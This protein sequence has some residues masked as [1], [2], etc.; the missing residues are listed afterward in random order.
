M[1]SHPPRE[2]ARRIALYLYM[3]LASAW[4]LG[5][6]VVV[7]LAAGSTDLLWLNMLKGVAFAVAT[8]LALYLIISRELEQRELLDRNHR[9]LTE[10]V[11]DL[12]FRLRVRPDLGF[13][14]VSPASVD[15][16]GYAPHEYYENP[17]AVLT[18][19]H[20]DDRERLSA[21]LSDPDSELEETELRWRH[22]DGRMVWTDI[23]V[24]KERDDAGR[25]VYISGVLRD[26]TK[27]RESERVRALLAETLEAAGEAVIITGRDGTI[28]YVNRAFTEIT[29]YDRE[30]A[31]GEN[32][33]I[34]RSGAQDA[35]FY[36]NL[37]STIASGRTFRGVLLNRRA[38]GRLYEQATSITP[39]LGADGAIEHYIA[40]AR[41]IT[42][43]SALEK[44]LR[45]TE[46]MD[47]VGQLAAG[48]AHDFRNLLNVILVNAELLRSGSG[49]HD[50]RGSRPAEPGGE[51]LEEILAAARR[52]VDLVGRLLRV[53]RHPEVDLRATDLVPMLRDMQGMLRATVLES[54]ALEVRMADRPV[55][56]RVDP[57]LLQ[58]AILNLIAN[59]GHATPAGGSVVVWIEP[60]EHDEPAPARIVV[61]DTGIGMDASVLARIFDP[62]FTTK[63]TGTGLGLPMVKSIVEMHGGT[64]EVES[65]PGQGTTVS[66]VLPTT[67]SSTGGRPEAGSEKPD[68]GL[69]PLP[70]V[71]PRILL[72]ED[73]PRLRAAAERA[74]RRLGY[75]VTS[76]EN[77]REAM[78]RLNATPDAWDLVI[79]DL[80]MP[81]VGGLELYE[82]VQQR[83]WRIPFLFMSGHGPEVV[84][85]AE[86][87][88]GAFTFL[89]KP[90]TMEKLAATV[91]GALADAPRL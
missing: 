15:I 18:T 13:E 48:V 59:A 1:T 68:S 29:G 76:A 91:R 25:V 75:E 72:V 33:R 7:A 42:V 69:D 27:Q 84:S 60:A 26:V 34:L 16:A 56:A 51:E 3:P 61:R 24:R 11:P 81:E 23:R 62:F 85:S 83:G 45:F 71:Q 19:V 63:E 37:W 70:E 31:I 5:T 90:W 9:T 58:D 21:L 64:I 53:A 89:E 8:G 28:E 80:I 79:S 17:E 65:K 88:A 46:K 57:D 87:S 86:G 6:D 43:Q 4:I 12:I 54:V 55:W 40:V 35:S 47:A 74:L 44:R 20:P 32:P 22:K 77:G 41:D 78:A 73:D 52:G 82:E 67:A 39:V 49:D 10:N 30:E 50:G 14:Y 36:A 66:V 2:T 38:D